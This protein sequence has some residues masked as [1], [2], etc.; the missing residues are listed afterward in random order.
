MPS[1]FGDIQIGPYN[2]MPPDYKGHN[3]PPYTAPETMYLDHMPHTY[4]NPWTGPE[5]YLG[6]SP[7]FTLKQVK[8]YYP[9]SEAY[10][11]LAKQTKDG[12]KQWDNEP[13][14]EKKVAVVHETWKERHLG[15]AFEPPYR[16]FA[17][18][19]G[20]W[21]VFAGKLVGSAPKVCGGNTWQGPV[22]KHYSDSV[23]VS[24]TSTTTQGWEFGL[25][26]EA[27]IDAKGA[28]VKRGS[29]FRWSKTTSES[30]EVTKQH[31]EDTTLPLKENQWGRLDIR[32]CAGLYAGYVAYRGIGD[33]SGKFGIYPMLAP[34]HV[35][36]F[37]SVVAEHT[38]LATSS[39]LSPEQIDALKAVAAYEEAAERVA[40]ADG[41]LTDA[42]LDHLR[43]SWAEAQPHLPTPITIAP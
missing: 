13:F 40:Q 42:D 9:L 32:M 24:V 33:G 4:Y 20:N 43:T 39:Q 36:G 8:E 11:E 38:M 10:A 41:Q 28:S 2:V 34:V 23:R 29:S 31:D 6:W 27:G 7:D 15:Q 22:T 14:D 19:N 16:D 1:A 37:G 26:A 30:T 3:A 21:V 35:P 5:I 17:G 12:R 25:T 18:F